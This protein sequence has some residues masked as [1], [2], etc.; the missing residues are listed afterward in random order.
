MTLNCPKR[1][2]LP[3]REKQ[4]SHLTRVILTSG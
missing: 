3:E 2:H 1:A 4:G